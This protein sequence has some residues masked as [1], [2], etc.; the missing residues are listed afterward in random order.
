MKAVMKACVTVICLMNLVFISYGYFLSNPEEIMKKFKDKINCIREPGPN[1]RKCEP[2][3]ELR[4]NLNFGFICVKKVFLG[5]HGSFHPKYVPP[6]QGHEKRSF[7]TFDIWKG[8]FRAYNT[9]YH[10]GRF[11]ETHH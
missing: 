10:C 5:P 1:C 6:Y 2:D 7:C 3:E 11:R 4:T 9:S 8:I